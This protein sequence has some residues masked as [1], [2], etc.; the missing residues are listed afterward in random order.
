MRVVTVS[1][2]QRHSLG[3]VKPAQLDIFCSFGVIFCYFLAE[4]WADTDMLETIEPGPARRTAFWTAVGVRS[5]GL[6]EPGPRRRRKT[7]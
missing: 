6:G 2:V 3:S 1:D 7:D 4:A 5:E